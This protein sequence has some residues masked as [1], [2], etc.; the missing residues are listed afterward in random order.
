M[1]IMK[2][3]GREEMVWIVVQ[4]ALCLTPAWLGQLDPHTV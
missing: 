4:G 1:V 3:E 2:M